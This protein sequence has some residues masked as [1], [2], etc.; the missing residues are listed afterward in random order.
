MSFLNGVETGMEGWPG[1][2]LSGNLPTGWVALAKRPSSAEPHLL[3]SRHVDERA[4]HRTRHI[5]IGEVN[6]RPH[7]VGRKYDKP[8]LALCSDRTKLRVR[9][10]NL[11]PHTF[12]IKRDWLGVIPVCL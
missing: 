6:R 10:A 4:E 2:E 3:R 9:V 8:R 12:E 11:S 5:R 1:M 7:H